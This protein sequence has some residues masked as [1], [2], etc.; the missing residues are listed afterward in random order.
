MT[1]PKAPPSP[2]PA[3]FQ[4]LGMHHEIL[5]TTPSALPRA[6][7]VALGQLA[8]LDA[9]L[10]RFRPDSQLSLLNRAASTGDASSL[11]NGLFVEHL[12]AAGRAARLSGGLVDPTVGAALVSAGYDADIDDVRA[13]DGHP[14]PRPTS[15]PGWRRVVCSPEGRVSVPAGTLLDFGSVS[16]AHAADTIAALLTRELPGGFLV[17]L[18][19]DI[20]TAG[21]APEGGWQVGI[22]AADGGIRQVVA[23]GDQAIATSS[24][25]LRRW[26]TDSGPVHHIIDPRTGLPAPDVWS[27]ASCIAHDAL[28]A[29]TASTSAII[30]GEQAPAWL[31]ERGVAARLERADGTAVLVGAWP[32]AEPDGAQPVSTAAAAREVAAC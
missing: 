27:Q 19:G 30:L 9:T 22:E 7:A 13:R 31:A 32:A 24:T 1:T 28:E 4:A 12:R 20:A 10:S 16:K 3:G 23:L 25:R 6:L 8:A 17:N 29:N 18:G 26:A 14:A 2:T 15:V 11:V 21:P 5:A